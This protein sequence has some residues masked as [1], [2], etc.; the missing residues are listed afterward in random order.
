[1]KKIGINI[2]STKDKEGKTIKY[3]ELIVRKYFINC[4][5]YKF[6]DA[7]HLEEEKNK[8]LDLLIALGGDGTILR[9][10]RAVEKFETPILAVNIGH[11]GFLSSIELSDFE[12][13]VKRILNKEFRI[14]DRMMIKCSL[15]KSNS[16]YY[17]TALNDIVVSKGTLSRAISYYIYIDNTFYINYKA[18]GLIISTP[19]GSTAY[20]LSAGGPIIY[21]TLD[22][23]SITP[24][25]PISVGIKTIVLHSENKINI[26]IKS[27]SEDAYLNID[28]QNV[29]ELNHDEEVFVE[30]LS[31]KCKLIKFNDYNYFKVLRKKIISRSIECEG[32]NS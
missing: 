32:D 10:A 17:Y 31:R 6:Y 9:A 16:E 1:M 19:T 27:Y 13:A 22:I 8:D 2:N 5:I 20:S 3:V 11:L 23:I 26:K 24:I 15:P 12:E 28:G 30:V 14:D 25:C 21:P 4:E 7:L 29:V 18:D